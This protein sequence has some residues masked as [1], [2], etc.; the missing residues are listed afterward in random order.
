[1][2][3]SVMNSGLHT[4]LG[5]KC[6]TCPVAQSVSEE[7]AGGRAVPLVTVTGQTLAYNAVTPRAAA[8]L[9]LASPGNKGACCSQGAGLGMQKWVYNN[10]KRE[11]PA[12]LALFHFGRFVSISILNVSFRF[13]VLIPEPV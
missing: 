2:L 5:R 10:P 9:Q 7:G 11:V 6:T 3:I 1:M 4:N 13:R 8:S 12:L